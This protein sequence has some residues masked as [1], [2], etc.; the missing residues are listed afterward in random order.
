MEAGNTETGDSGYSFYSYAVSDD[1]FN[2]SLPTSLQAH[3]IREIKVRVCAEND[4]TQMGKSRTSHEIESQ[5][6]NRGRSGR[7]AGNVNQRRVWSKTR[8]LRL[9]LV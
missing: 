7:V 4:T 9:R 3:I 8:D 2:Y 5:T 1:G 6:P